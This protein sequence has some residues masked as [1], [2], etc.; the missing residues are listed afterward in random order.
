M[1]ETTIIYF[2]F[3]SKLWR[4]RRVPRPRFAYI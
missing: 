1:H 3:R 2:H 4:H